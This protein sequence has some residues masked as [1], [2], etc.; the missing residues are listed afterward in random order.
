MRATFSRWPLVIALLFFFL[1]CKK[2]ESDPQPI[3]TPIDTIK[4]G[5]YFP[6]YP[7]SWWK[8]KLTDSTGVTVATYSTYPT[9]L[10]HTYCKGRD[11]WV[12]C[13][14]PSDT[15]F[16]PFYN[17]APIYRYQYI[18]YAVAPFLKEDYLYDFLTETAGACKIRPNRKFCD[19]RYP[20]FNCVEEEITHISK[21]KLGSDSVLI[22]KGH[23]ININGL[24]NIISPHQIFQ[25][26]YIK[27]L[28]MNLFWIVDTLSNDTVRK[29]QLIDHFVNH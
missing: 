5:S 1:S 24:D 20:G 21:A 17:G 19:P 28:G 3:P 29:I 27:N 12:T 7:G 4:P 11:N 23:F 26:E 18:D 8:Y 22:A 16:V 25:K 10:K 2:Q 14:S 9:Y 13:K 6:V 15:V